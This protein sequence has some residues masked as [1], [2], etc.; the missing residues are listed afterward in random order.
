[1]FTLGFLVATLFCTYLIDYFGVNLTWTTFLVV[2][3]GVIAFSLGG[4]SAFLVGTRKENV[5]DYKQLCREYRP[6]NL[7]TFACIAF[8]AVT[9]LLFIRNVIAVSGVFTTLTDVTY[10]YRSEGYDGTQLQPFY[11]NQMV[12]FFKAIAYVYLFYFVNNVMYTR[13]LRGNVL[14]LIPAALLI[15]MSIFGASRAELV[16]LFIYIVTLAFFIY[17]RMHNYLMRVSRKIIKYL[18]ISVI[19]FLLMFSGVR[20]LVGRLNTTDPMTYISSYTGGSIELLDLY[21]RDEGL[22]A[23]TQV[24]GDETFFALESDLG[25]VD[26]SSHL[27]FRYST[28]GILAGNV[29]TCFRKYLHDFGF[30][31]MLVIE[32]MLGLFFTWWYLRTRSRVIRDPSDHRLIYFAYFYVP[33]VKSFVQEETLSSYLCLNSLVMLVLFWFVYWLTVKAVPRERPCSVETRYGAGQPRPQV[34]E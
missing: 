4:G 21:V 14:F 5:V 13:K 6:N 15:A 8:C 24:F 33:I 9:A 12:K 19:A 22:E 1:V 11:V 29:Y 34:G 27:E 3:S 17:G 30:L 10:A 2:V 31:G 20:S 18:I 26:G 7:I 32:Y 23:Q 28:T 25:I 16:T